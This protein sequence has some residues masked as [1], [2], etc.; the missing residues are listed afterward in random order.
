[1]TRIRGSGS[2][3]LFRDGVSIAYA[4][5]GAVVLA[6]GGETPRSVKGEM[7][8]VGYGIMSNGGASVT[9]A[10]V[11]NT[12]L[13]YEAFFNGSKASEDLFG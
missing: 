5:S 9:S 10:N 3:A 8:F 11:N 2:A 4:D 1:M 7:T 13:G 6:S 12:A